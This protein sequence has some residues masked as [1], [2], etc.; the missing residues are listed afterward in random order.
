MFDYFDTA[1]VWQQT[2]SPHKKV[3]EE[4]KTSLN[5]ELH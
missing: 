1:I 4:E 2:A 3:I 5:R